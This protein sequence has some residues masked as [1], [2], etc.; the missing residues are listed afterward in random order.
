M[1]QSRAIR[2][3]GRFRASSSFH[4]RPLRD[5]LLVRYHQQSCYFV[6]ESRFWAFIYRAAGIEPPQSA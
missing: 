2:I 6:R 5:G 1:K 4:V 3:A